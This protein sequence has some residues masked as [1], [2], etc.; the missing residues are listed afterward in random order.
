MTVGE[1]KAYIASEVDDL[2]MS[3]F[4]AAELL[5]FINQAAAECQ[6][7]LNRSAMYYNTKID[8]SVSTVVNQQLYAIPTDCM[9]INRIELVMNPG[10]NEQAYPVKSISLNEK[11]AFPRYGQP[12]C[13]YWAS[14]QIALAPIPQNVWVI[15]YYY[16]YRIPAVA[17]DSDTV[18]VPIDYHEYICNLAIKK[19]FLK[20]GRNADLVIQELKDVE[21]RLEAQAQSRTQDRARSVIVVDGDD[22]GSWY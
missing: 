19:C 10:V 17:G 6:K 21:N 3:Y 4:T 5:R 16:T 22:Y 14:T 12:F 9:E 7:L 13:W 15:R 11:D 2:Q 8:I 20:D 18:D 1:M